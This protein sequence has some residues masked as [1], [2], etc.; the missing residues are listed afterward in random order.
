MQELDNDSPEFF[1]LLDEPKMA[2]FLEHVELCL[3]P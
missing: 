1:R 2:T 3:A